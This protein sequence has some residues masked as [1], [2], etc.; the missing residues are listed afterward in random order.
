MKFEPRHWILGLLPTLAALLSGMLT[1]SSVQA[2]SILA[3]WNFNSLAA[4]TDFS[5]PMSADLSASGVT[6]GGLTKGAGIDPFQ[7]RT[8]GGQNVL[9]FRNDVGVNTKALA[10]AND[11][12]GEFSLTAQPGNALN[13]TGFDIKAMSANGPPNFQTRFYFVRYSTDNFATFNEIIADTGVSGHGLVSN[14]VALNL[15]NLTSTIRFRIYGYNNPSGTTSPD[16]GLQYDDI[17][18]RGAVVPEPGTLAVLGLGL[19]GLFGMRRR[20]LQPIIG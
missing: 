10:L 19:A 13:I 17:V 15:T 2:S 18:V 1:V 16:R 3:E 9:K 5:G 20:P 4:N 7:T 11:T 8:V 14:S 12:Y 6:V